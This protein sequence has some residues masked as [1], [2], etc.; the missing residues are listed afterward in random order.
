MG[1]NSIAVIAKIIFGVLDKM[2][3]RH[4]V[5]HFDSLPDILLPDVQQT[6]SFLP[7]ISCTYLFSLSDITSKLTTAETKRLAVLE[8]SVGHFKI[9]L[10]MSGIFGNHCNCQ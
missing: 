9:V 1:F 10:D 3:G 7:D 8:L 5:G 4:S 2:S 6:G